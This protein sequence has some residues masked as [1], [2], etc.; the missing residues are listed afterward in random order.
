MSKVIITESNL[1]NIAEAIRN[2][3]GSSATYTPG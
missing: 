2:K 1:T 3:T